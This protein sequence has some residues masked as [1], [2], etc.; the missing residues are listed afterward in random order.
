[1]PKSFCS[2]I[3]PYACLKFIRVQIKLADFKFPNI[4]NESL[5]ISNPERKFS[6]R[7]ASSSDNAAF[8]GD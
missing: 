5:G 2:S 8:Y 1:M 7:M 3:H 4:L 6:G